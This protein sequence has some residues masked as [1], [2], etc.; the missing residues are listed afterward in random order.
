MQS[1]FSASDPFSVHAYR[2]LFANSPRSG[3]GA[4]SGADHPDRGC[5][6]LRGDGQFG[7]V[8]SAPSCL[9]GRCR[10]PQQV[11]TRCFLCGS[12]SAGAERTYRG[13][14][15]AC[16]GCR[17][18]RGDYRQL[19][20]AQVDG[21]AQ[22]ADTEGSPRG[23]AVSAAP[24]TES[25]I[26]PVK[27]TCAHRSSDCRFSHNASCR[28][29]ATAA[30]GRNLGGIHREM[31]DEKVRHEST[32]GRCELGRSRARAGRIVTIDGSGGA[33]RWH[34]PG[35]CGCGGVC[36]RLPWRRRLRFHRPRPVPQEWVWGVA[37]GTAKPGQNQ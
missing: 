31:W 19:L 22:H 1:W 36:Q 20:L 11:V 2:R 24:A 15:G 25:V 37:D 18:R 4:A 28:P 3:V 21:Q 14:P 13:R 9:G 6:R 32:Y 23:T 26:C 17:A 29:L 35:G 12:Q 5:R 7:C 10:P 30:S 33:R 16:A 8:R 34:A 27:L